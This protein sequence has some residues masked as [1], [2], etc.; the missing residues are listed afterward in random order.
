[1]K[2][3]IALIVED[4]PD[5]GELLEILLGTAGL[6]PFLV[7]TGGNAL[8][9]MTASVPDLV[10][11]DL[12]LPDVS[13]GD[14]LRAIRTN[15]RSAEIPVIVTTGYSRMAQRVIDSREADLVMVKPVACDVL[16]R[17]VIEL[18]GRDDDRKQGCVPGL[19]Q[20]N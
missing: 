16:K 11:L 19:P 4:D 2:P 8:S 13:G 14:V 20:A 3:R 6:V 7:E 5:T 17:K 9:L 12:D 15:P 1:M 10:V 18:V